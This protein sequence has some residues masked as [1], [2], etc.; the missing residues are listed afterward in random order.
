[1][2]TMAIG[3][4]MV[5]SLVELDVH[6]RASTLMDG[7]FILV[8]DDAKMLASEFGRY[9]SLDF[10]IQVVRIQLRNM[11]MPRPDAHDALTQC[12]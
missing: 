1:V 8:C 7:A 12:Q 4:P 3:T 6:L 5:L 2:L 10:V 9:G 11:T